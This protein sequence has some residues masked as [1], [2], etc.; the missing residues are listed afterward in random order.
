MP[1]LS[2]Y[3]IRLNGISNLFRFFPSI[4]RDLI[5]ILFYTTESDISDNVVHSQRCP[6]LEYISQGQTA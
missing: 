1:S 4:T 2:L 6:R 5:I 3:I